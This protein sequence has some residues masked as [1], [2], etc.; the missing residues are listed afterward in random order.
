MVAYRR[1]CLTCCEGPCGAVRLALRPSCQLSVSKQSQLS[2]VNFT[3]LV[4]TGTTKNRHPCVTR[5]AW[6]IQHCDI[7]SYPV[8]ISLES[9]ACCY[10]IPHRNHDESQSIHYSLPYSMFS[11]HIPTR[12][13]CRPGNIFFAADSKGHGSTTFATDEAIR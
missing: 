4:Q 9:C 3:V 8:F 5:N 2:Q 6:M 13:K 1:Q 12:L 7:R 10:K 11:S